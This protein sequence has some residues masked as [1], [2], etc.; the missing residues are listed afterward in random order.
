MPASLGITELFRDL[1]RCRVAL[2]VGKPATPAHRPPVLGQGGDGYP[3]AP[4]L[5][6]L[7]HRLRSH[8]KRWHCWLQRGQ[9][10]AAPVPVTL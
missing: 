3:W 4:Q 2:A 7:P 5:A 10:A 6:A 1:A 8:P 9:S